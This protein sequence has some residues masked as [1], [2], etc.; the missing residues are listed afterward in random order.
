MTGHAIPA[1]PDCAL[2]GY[3]AEV[4]PAPPLPPEADTPTLGAAPDAPVLLPEADPK[5]LLE[6][7]EDAPPVE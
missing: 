5:L 4:L 1:F 3:R 2:A 6:P 7:P